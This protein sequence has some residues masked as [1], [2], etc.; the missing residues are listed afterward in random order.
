[1]EHMPD[2]YNDQ[3]LS[4]CRKGKKLQAIKLYRE[5]TGISVE[6]CKAYVESLVS[7]FGICSPGREKDKG[8]DHKK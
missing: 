6:D 5:A 3:I 7:R 8:K 1:M 4:L 2:T